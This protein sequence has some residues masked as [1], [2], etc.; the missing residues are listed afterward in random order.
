MAKSK[1]DAESRKALDDLINSAEDNV[2]NSLKSSI[3]KFLKRV[4]KNLEKYEFVAS[5]NI[6]Q[7]IKALPTKKKE[8]LLTARVEIA[9]YWED[10]ENGTKPKGYTKENRK[11]L[12]PRILAWINTKDSLLA[13]ANDEKEK[14]SLSYA[15]ATNILKNGTIKRFNYRGKKF[16]TDE[17]PQLEKDFIEEFSK[18][19][20]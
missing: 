17:L 16:L 7:S 3:N 18:P 5:G 6:Y 4:K 12:Q 2:D 10:L 11:Q 9:D 20:E 15:I 14:K 1:L 13:I 8:S 19:E